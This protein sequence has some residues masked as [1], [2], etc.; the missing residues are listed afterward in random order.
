M[1]LTEMRNP[2]TEHIDQMTTAEMLKVMNAENYRVAEAVDHA[3]PQIAP[4]VDHIAEQIAFGG[5]MLYVGAGTSGRLG[6]LDA[7][8]CPPTFGVSPETVVALIAGGR[9][10]MFRAAPSFEDSVQEGV[11]AIEACALTARDTVIGISA[12]GGAKFVLGAMRKAREAGAA[13]ASVCSNPNT[14]MSA[15]ADYPV[16]VDTGAEAITGSTRLKAGSAQKMVLN[17]ISTAVMIKLGKVYENYMVGIQ[18]TNEK[19][20]RRAI[21]TVRALTGADEPE[22]AKA[23]A[24]CHDVRQAV[25]T[26]RKGAP[27]K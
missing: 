14:P 10:A 27:R 22:A 9:D 3:L 23:L 15:E 8:E 11:W 19:L 5:R 16:F 25:D 7:A 21:E 13:T 6:V 12:A 17:L 24:R 4:L 1:L 2:R 20:R 18:P 26:L